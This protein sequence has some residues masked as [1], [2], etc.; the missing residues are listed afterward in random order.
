MKKFLLFV[1]SLALIFSLTAC[2]SRSETEPADDEEPIEDNTEIDDEPVPEDPEENY[3]IINPLTGEALEEDVS[4]KRPYAFMLNNLKKALPQCGVGKADIIYEI[5]AEGGISRMLAIFQDLTDVGTIGSIRSARP[6]YIDIALAYDPIYIHAGGSEQAY[7]DLSSKG[8]LN[9]DG[10]NGRRGTQIFYRDAQR[11]ASVGYE[12]SMFTTSELI[13]QYI[14]PMDIRHNHE[15]GYQFKQTYSSEPMPDG[16]DAE[17]I[18][19][20][21]SSSNTTEFKYDADKKAYLVYD[22]TDAYVDGNSGEQV[23]AKNVLCLFTDISRIS[24]DT[25]G[26]MKVRTT[27]TG[28]GYF[29]CEGKIVPIKWSRDGSYSQFVYTLEDGTPLSLGRGMT[30]ICVLSSASDVEY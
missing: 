29:A 1:L 21:F 23:A 14:Y 26:R 7:S 20:H 12:H 19:A 11:R 10:V 2:G 28:S 17:H 18:T 22:Y 24:G 15:D 9:F 27:G 16:K 13:E 5:V 4:Y 8:V 30:Y 6:Y 3:D 25:A